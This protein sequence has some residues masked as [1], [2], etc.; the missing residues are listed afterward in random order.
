MEEKRNCL[1]EEWSRVSF[2]ELENIEVEDKAVRI[3]YKSF[4]KILNSPER[5][6]RD[7]LMILKSP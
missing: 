4:F 1:I 3:F 2:E 6:L 5:I 7:F